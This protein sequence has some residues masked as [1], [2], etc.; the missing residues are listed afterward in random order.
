MKTITGIEK[1]MVKT[2]L[3]LGFIAAISLLPC[4]KVSWAQKADTTPVSIAFDIHSDRIDMMTGKKL[5]DYTQA[6]REGFQFFEGKRESITDHI[7]YMFSIVTT[8]KITDILR[9]RKIHTQDIWGI[10]DSSDKNTMLEANLIK[11]YGVSFIP[12]NPVTKK[13]D[14]R[15]YV[16]LEDMYLIQWA[17]IGALDKISISTQ[18]QS[19]YESEEGTVY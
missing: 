14:P 5:P 10:T 13:P 17:P 6:Q 12:I 16:L 19:E 18:S 2:C 9:M 1:I 15:V 8:V 7:S 11:V 3:R 4:N